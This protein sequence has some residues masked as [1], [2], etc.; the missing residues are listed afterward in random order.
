MGT[1]RKYKKIF[2]F[3]FFIEETQQEQPVNSLDSDAG[4]TC[5]A[6]EV[7]WVSYRANSL[8]GK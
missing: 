3:S 8:D 1:S 5:R 7:S 2:H 4:W 6:R